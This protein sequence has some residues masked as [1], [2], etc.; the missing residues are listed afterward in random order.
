MITNAHIERFKYMGFWCGL[1][2][3]TFLSTQA[4]SDDFAV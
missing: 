2:L 3:S 1:K 4:A